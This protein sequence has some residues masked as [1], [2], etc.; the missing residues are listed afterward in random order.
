MVA[1]LPIYAA[2][3]LV[4]GEDINVRQVFVGSGLSTAIGAANGYPMSYLV[5][6]VND[7]TGTRPCGRKLYPSFFREQNPVTKKFILGG[8]AAASVGLMAMVYSIT[9]PGYNVVT[10]QQD[11][12]KTEKTITLEA[13]AKDNSLEK[14]TTAYYYDFQNSI[15]NKNNVQND[16]AY[17]VQK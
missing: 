14:L 16:D 10:P 8:L 11:T 5:D 2:S 1:A 6:V 4:A 12:I 7:L 15:Q 9:P 3:Q 17:G 13:P